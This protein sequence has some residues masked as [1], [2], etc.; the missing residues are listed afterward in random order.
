MR[1]RRTV[2]LVLA[3]CWPMVALAHTEGSVEGFL[4]GIS[5]PVFGLDHFLAMLSV[6]VVSAQLGGRQIYIVP[7]IFVLSMICGAII[8]WNGREW[9]FGEQGIA[10]SVVVLGAAI[11]RVNG[12]GS[13]I[14]AAVTAFFGVLHGH[15]HGLEM[16]RA[17]DPV[18]YAAGFVIGTA[19]I[20][21][22]GVAIG[23]WLSRRESSLYW[24]RHMGSAICG[25]GLLIL[26]QSLQGT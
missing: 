10:L 18:Y 6:G 14:V 16:P 20:H 12:H 5:H 9:P 4:S 13:R 8:G 19:A 2:C 22:L 15:A 23:H 3:A 11:V 1:I 17:A 26:V 7:S 25:V 21:L 24:L